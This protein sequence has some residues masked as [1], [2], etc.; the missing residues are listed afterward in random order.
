M[1]PKNLKSYQPTCVP[2]V[3]R[4]PDKQGFTL[5]E[6]LLSVIVIAIISS[7]AIPVYQSFQVRNDLDIAV[8]SIAHSYRRAQLLAQGSEDDTSSGVKIGT[9]SISVF[10]GA[11]YAT[12]DSSWDEIFDLPETIVASGLTE[13]VFAKFTGLPSATGTTIMT[14]TVNE[15]RNITINEKGMVDY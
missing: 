8:T 13:V 7:I 9:S 4:L 10:R 1:K 12:R 14:S 2:Q 15:T 3:G 5:L 6:I 11:S